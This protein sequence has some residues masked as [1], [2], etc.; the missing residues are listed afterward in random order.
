MTSSCVKWYAIYTRPH[1]EKKIAEKLAQ[2]HIEAYLPL[3]T[4]LRQ[5]S[6][7]KKKVSEPLFSCYLFVKISTRDYFKVLNT[8]G[9]VRYITFEGKAVP[10]PD[11]QIQLIK[12]LLEFEL[13]TPDDT[14]KL[15]SGDTVEVIAGPLIG[16]RG[17]MI[18][19][20]GKKRIV[21]RIKEID[22]SI[23]VNI[24]L[25]ILKPIDVRKS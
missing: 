17:E 7:R 22:K 3:R 16:I 13:E 20:S 11:S 6:D 1:H 5:W 24:S 23:L 21:I 9:V 8:P 12:N 2:E 15:R 14:V 19:L 25:S 18:E 4:T 10:I